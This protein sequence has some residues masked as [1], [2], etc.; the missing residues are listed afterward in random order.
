[1][2]DP[3]GTLRTNSVD[4]LQ[5]AST[6]ELVEVLKG[7][8]QDMILISVP[9]KAKSN[10]EIEIDLTKPVSPETSKLLARAAPLIYSAIARRAAEE[11]RDRLEGDSE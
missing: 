2:P 10:T 8:F 5:Y 6:E 1:M 4:P 11:A 3:A 9:L 7:H